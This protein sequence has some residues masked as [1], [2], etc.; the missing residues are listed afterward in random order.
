MHYH[1]RERP[2]WQQRKGLSKQTR[3]LSWSVVPGAHVRSLLFRRAVSPAPSV[4]PCSSWRQRMSGAWKASSFSI[5]SRRYLDDQS[6]AATMGRVARVRRHL[7]RRSLSDDPM[8]LH[9]D[10]LMTQRASTKR[11]TSDPFAGALPAEDLGR[12]GGVHLARAQHVGEQIERHHREV[13][14]RG[15]R[16]RRLWRLRLPRRRPGCGRR[17]AG[18]HRAADARDGAS[19]PRAVLAAA[20]RCCADELPHLWPRSWARW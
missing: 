20:A 16:L 4:A 7:I 2:F 13:R 18:G 6:N 10:S 1:R 5:R 9:Q 19:V 15:G 14:R 11:A 3:G 12:D 17:C 8:C